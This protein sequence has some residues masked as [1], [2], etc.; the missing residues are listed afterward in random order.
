[1][2]VNTCRN[3]RELL[4]KI[5]KDWSWKLGGTRQ[6]V[7]FMLDWN[8]QTPS[9]TFA[10]IQLR[11]QPGRRHTWGKRRWPRNLLYKRSNICWKGH[12][13]RTWN[14][15]YSQKD[16]GSYYTGRKSSDA[17]SGLRQPSFRPRCSKFL[18]N[19]ALIRFVGR[20]VLKDLES[21]WKNY[22]FRLAN[23]RWQSLLISRLIW[24]VKDQYLFFIDQPGIC[25]LLGL[26]NFN[27]LSK[28]EWCV[29][30]RLENTLNVQQVLEKQLIEKK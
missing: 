10:F 12:T 17:A 13:V 9:W 6:T 7:V 1:M 21:C 2:G 15:T 20:A 30:L 4:H 5:G 18:H 28:F 23:S 16:Q 26:E 24:L 27:P 3:V 11:A 25:Y 19:A 14:C 8:K 29:D 22:E